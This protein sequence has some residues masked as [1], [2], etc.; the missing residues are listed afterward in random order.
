MSYAKDMLD[1]ITTNKEKDGNSLIIE[2]TRGTYT[3]TAI[4]AFLGL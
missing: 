2:K 1:K 4:G 3:G